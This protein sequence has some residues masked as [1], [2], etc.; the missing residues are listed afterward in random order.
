MGVSIRLGV[1]GLISPDK[2]DLPCIARY[3][4]ILTMTRRLPPSGVRGLIIW[5]HC[6]H[7]GKLLDA[8]LELISN[9]LLD[10]EVKL[11]F[12]CYAHLACRV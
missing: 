3:G 6:K 5:Y 1:D 8:I 4:S 10:E 11:G 2:H 7:V 9:H 12:E